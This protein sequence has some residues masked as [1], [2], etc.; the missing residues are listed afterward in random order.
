MLN[1]YVGGQPYRVLIHNKINRK[2]ALHRLDDL[3]DDDCDA[4]VI[5]LKVIVMMVAYLVPSNGDSDDLGGGDGHAA[6]DDG[7]HGTGAT[8]VRVRMSVEYHSMR[9]WLH[10]FG[11][12][13]TIIQHL[14][15]LI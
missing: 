10:W 6:C 5:V 14:Q 7:R 3:D 12:N 9:H 4:V 1:I 2:H 15:C 8:V 13:H 11:K